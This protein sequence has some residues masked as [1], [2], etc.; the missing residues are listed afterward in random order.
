MDTT[1]DEI[2]N[3]KIKLLQPIN[4]PRVN[5]D[6]I[7]LSSW[8]KFRNGHNNFIELGC[9]AGAITILLALRNSKIRITGVDIQSELIELANKNLALNNLDTSKINFKTGDLRDK[10]FLPTQFYDA[11]IMNPPYT[12]KIHGRANLSVSLK[13]ARLDENCTPEDLA[14]TASRILKSRGRLFTVFNSE[15]VSEFLAVMSK[16]NLIPKRIK[17]IY[18]KQ[19][20]NSNIFLCECI[21]DAGAGTIIL[22]PMIIYNLDGSYTQEV[23]KAYD[24]NT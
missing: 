1:L 21:K 5:L 14:I 3:G 10:N 22:P 15:R 8:V 13:T 20:L 7:L 6:T 9:A 24:L 12:S 2:L 18:P 11:V 16:N 4:G 17:F 23:L 19:D